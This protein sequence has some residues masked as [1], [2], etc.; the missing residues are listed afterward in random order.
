MEVERKLSKSSI[1]SGSGSAGGLAPVEGTGGVET[2]EA[3][4]GDEAG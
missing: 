2:A 1:K 4:G 3:F